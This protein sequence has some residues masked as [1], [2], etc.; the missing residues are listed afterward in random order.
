VITK[1]QA[2]EIAKQ[3]LVKHGHLVH[4]YEISVDTDS[5]DSEQWVIWCE[6]VGA[7]PIPGGKHGVLVNKINGQAQFLP[8][9]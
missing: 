2:I 5:S 8:G 7:F 9:E 3:E 1:D 4:D 6:K